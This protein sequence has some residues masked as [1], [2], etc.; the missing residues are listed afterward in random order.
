MRANLCELVDAMGLKK[1]WMGLNHRSTYKK[2]TRKLFKISIET[3]IYL[4]NPVTCN[5]IVS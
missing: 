1:I 5:L 2:N 3:M 4:M